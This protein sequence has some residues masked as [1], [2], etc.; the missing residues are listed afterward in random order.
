MKPERAKE[1]IANERAQ[2]ERE[3]ASI[4]GEGTEEGDER[5]EP[6]DRDSEGLYQDEFDAG[7]EQ[8]S[9]GG[10]SLTVVGALERPNGD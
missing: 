4:E 10:G 5:R 7:R 2:V 6:G 9:A 8:G 1:L 3:I